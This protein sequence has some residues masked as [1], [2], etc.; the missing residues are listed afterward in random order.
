M[1][2]KAPNVQRTTLIYLLKTWRPLKKEKLGESL[3]CLK[4]NI[5]KLGVAQDLILTF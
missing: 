2:L 3:A 4:Q 5:K 1:I